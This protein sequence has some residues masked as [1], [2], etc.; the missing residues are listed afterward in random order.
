[1]MAALAAS[2]G[3]PVLHNQAVA[4][5]PPRKNAGGPM[6]VYHD[7]MA[8]V[9][10]EHQIVGGSLAIA[11]DDR[12]VLAR[13]YGLADADTRRPVTRGTLFCIAS[14]SKAVTAAAILRLV[15]MGKLRLNARLVRVL[16]DIHPPGGGFADPDFGEITV[17]HILYHASGI[18]D[19]VKIPGKKRRRPGDEDADEDDTET[20]DRP[21]AMLR[22]AMSGPLDFPPGSDHHYS[23]SAF[24]IVQ[25]V[26]ERASGQSFVPFVTNEVLRPMGI[27]HALMEKL[28]PVPDET[29]RYVIGPKGRHAAVR[30]SVNWLF[31]PTDM[32][33]FL[34]SVAGTRG[35]PFLS[36]RMYQAMVAVPRPPVL[37]GPGGKHVG[38]GWDAVVNTPRGAGFS[39]NGG[40]AGVSAWAEHRPDGVSW[41]FMLN[42]NGDNKFGGRNPANEIIRLVNQ[43]L[44]R[45]SEWPAVNL[46]ET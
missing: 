44:D 16:D 5:Q 22:A 3:W 20:T 41:A 26:V 2:L 1:M 36:P 33:R 7:I 24:M 30:G 17:H 9:L 21:A 27:T 35:Q 39:K 34:T 23:N 8:S 12:L 46:F 31:T 42:T 18:P 4:R 38:L 40:K 10:T 25:L 43:G 11:R 37:P 15:D 29:A 28:E 14:V 6:R 13:G 32:V 45:Q 19:R